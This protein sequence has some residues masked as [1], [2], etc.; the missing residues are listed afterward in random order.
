MGV[1]R[2][3]PAL[4]AANGFTYEESCA[5]TGQ[6]FLFSQGTTAGLLSE[7][8]HYSKRQAVFHPLFRATVGRAGPARRGGATRSRGDLEK[9]GWRTECI[10]IAHNEQQMGMSMFRNVSTRGEPS[11]PR[12]PRSHSAGAFYPPRHPP[13]LGARKKPQE[14]HPHTPVSLT[15]SPAPHS[16]REHTRTPP[17]DAQMY[18]SPSPMERT[19]YAHIGTSRVAT[20]S[21]PRYSA[22]P[23]FSSAVSPPSS[24]PHLWGRS[25]RIWPFAPWPTRLDEPRVRSARWAEPSSK[26]CPSPKR[27]RSRSFRSR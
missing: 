11:R 14:S 16:R 20:F 6:K 19:Q 26:P 17:P 25:A 9:P 3:H 24:P 21:P 22:P 8:S 4:V 2:S 15:T 10:E 1:S 12:L 13:P 7:S 23:C 5:K 18:Y 27:P